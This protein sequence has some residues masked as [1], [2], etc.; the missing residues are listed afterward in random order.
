MKIV[1]GFTLL[2]CIVS[3]SISLLAC[4]LLAQLLISSFVAR[5]R[6]MQAFEARHELWSVGVQ[7]RSDVQA[8]PQESAAWLSLG[9]TE[10]GWRDE[11]GA[12]IWSYVSGVIRRRV[13]SSVEI[14]ARK[15]EACIFTVQCTRGLVCAVVCR[16]RRGDVEV[17]FEIPLYEWIGLCRV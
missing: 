4:S 2:E 16:L 12:T 14:V 15:I 5:N 1:T 9:G 10:I 3:L 7:L 17:C 8:A 6:G 11:R 13:G